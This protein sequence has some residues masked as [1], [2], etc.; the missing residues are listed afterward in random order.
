LWYARRVPRF[1]FHV[2]D[3]DRLTEDPDG[4]ELPDLAAAGAKARTAIREAAA[5]PGSAG[6]DLGRRRFEIADAGGRVLATV[7]FRDVFGLH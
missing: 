2:R 1:Y 7:A 6:L 5:R 4:A 3:G